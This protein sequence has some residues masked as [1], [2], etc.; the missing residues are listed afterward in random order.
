MPPRPS[1]PE[2]YVRDASGLLHGPYPQ[3]PA[4][5][6]GYEVVELA[7]DGV[8]ADAVND[9]GPYFVACS[10][11]AVRGPFGS[12]DVRRLVAQ[13]LCGAG[14]RCAPGH[15]VAA[16]AASA[17][18]GK[19]WK[20]HLRPHRWR[21]TRFVAKQAKKGAVQTLNAAATAAP[22]QLYKTWADEEAEWAKEIVKQ[23]SVVKT[24]KPSPKR[25]GPP[26]PQKRRGP[27]PPPR[28]PDGT[29]RIAGSLD[30]RKFDDIAAQHGWKADDALERRAALSGLAY[31]V[32]ALGVVAGGVAGAVHFEVLAPADAKH[33]AAAAAHV[34]LAWC[35]RHVGMARDL[36]P[37]RWR[38]VAAGAADALSDASDAGLVAE[39]AADA[40]SAAAAAAVDAAAETIAET[41]A[42]TV[43]GTVA[44]TVAAAAETLV[45]EA[46]KLR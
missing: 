45:E 8:N 15:R 11:G 6:A 32:G 4:V 39:T 18:A 25:G 31:R 23:Q 26:V 19:T 33:F 35:R 29:Q 13:G 7:P 34:A 42:E 9:G 40:A 41:V 16:P 20:R 46:V 43:A 30:V 1:G 27:R 14:A 2:F 21:A 22:P 28:R 10:D 17:K 24:K 38:P 3:P 5:P 44:E 37:A 36:L 12:A